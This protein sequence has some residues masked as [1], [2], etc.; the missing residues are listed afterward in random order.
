MLIFPSLPVHYIIKF[1]KYLVEDSHN[2]EVFTPNLA[3]F[4]IMY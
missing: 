4:S 2:L 3:T 1:H